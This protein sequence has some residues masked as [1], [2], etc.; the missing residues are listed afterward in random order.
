MAPHGRQALHQQRNQLHR[1]LNQLHRHA[2]RTIRGRRMR[3][4]DQAQPVQG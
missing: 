4:Q 1:Q 3:G 2:S